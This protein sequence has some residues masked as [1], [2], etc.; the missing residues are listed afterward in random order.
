MERVV[1]MILICFTTYPDIED[2]GK[3]KR[4]KEKIANSKHNK[5]NI[6]VKVKIL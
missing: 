4:R 5:K 6:T 1:E 2:Y 3:Q